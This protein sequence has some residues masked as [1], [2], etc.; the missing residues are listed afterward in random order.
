MFGAVD[1]NVCNDD[2]DGTRNNENDMDDVDKD[3]IVDDD[4]RADADDAVYDGVVSIC[5]LGQ[6][7]QCLCRCGYCC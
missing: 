2:N 1:A 4:N 6:W 5:L 7:W 3:D